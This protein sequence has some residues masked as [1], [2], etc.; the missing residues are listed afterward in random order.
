MQT[1]HPI[2]FTTFLQVVIQNV[3]GSKLTTIVLCLSL[4]TVGAQATSRPTSPRPGS[5]RADGAVSTRAS[6]TPSM[7][8]ER[9]TS[10]LTLLPCSTG[11]RSRSRSG[12]RRRS[13]SGTPCSSRDMP[14]GL[15]DTHRS[16]R[17]T[18]HRSRD[19]DSHRM[20]RHRPMC[21]RH[22]RSRSLRY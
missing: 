22:R 15:R 19:T 13:S 8:L 9:A 10:P 20:A 11:R 5:R 16:R 4:R 14:R 1:C 3:K 6:G 12:R 21:H 17:D 7:T 2:N 18:L